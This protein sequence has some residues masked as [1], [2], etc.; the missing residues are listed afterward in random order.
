MKQRVPDEA[1]GERVDRYV[2]SLPEVGSRAEA[3]RLLAAGAVLLDGQAPPKSRRLAGG[4]ALDVE[5]PEPAQR[6][7]E[8]QPVDFR[9]AWEDEYLVV[10]E[11]PAG[12]VVHPAPGHP[13]GTLVHGLVAVGAAGGEEDRPGIVH[14][15]DRDTSG[16]IVVARSSGTTARSSS[17][18]R[19]RGGD[20]SR[21]R[22]AA[23]GATPFAT[24]STLTRPAMR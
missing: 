9:I 20:A 5:L 14:R 18:G 19:A 17:A 10:V 22:S 23:I 2:A 15:L 3:E 7:P 8:P 12:V 4:E 6:G 21:R 24:R 11:K 13:A 16:L 1:A